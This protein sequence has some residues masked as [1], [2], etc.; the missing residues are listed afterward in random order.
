MRNKLF[1]SHHHHY[2]RPVSYL[3][4]APQRRFYGRQFFFKGPSDWSSSTQWSFS[5]LLA[6]ADTKTTS[7]SVLSQPSRC[8]NSLQ[9]SRYFR[10]SASTPIT[11]LDLFSAGM[12]VARLVKDGLMS[13]WSDLTTITTEESVQL[14]GRGD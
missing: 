10:R 1:H 11:L 3:S 7:E 4:P 5:L 9:S 2:R 13:D 8:C 12:A 14:V 6:T